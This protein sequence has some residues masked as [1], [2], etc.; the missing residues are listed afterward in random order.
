M[1]SVDLVV[2]MGK[3]NQVILALPKW[4][5]LYQRDQIAAPTHRFY[6]E[7]HQ[8]KLQLFNKKEMSIVVLAHTMLLNYNSLTTLYTPWTRMQP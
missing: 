6:E 8:T 1:K 5:T 2:K 4:E 3:R 7:L